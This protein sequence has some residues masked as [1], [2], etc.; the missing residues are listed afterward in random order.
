MVHQHARGSKTFYPLLLQD[1]EIFDVVSH[2]V[3]NLLYIDTIHAHMMNF[4]EKCAH[5][6]WSVHIGN[7]ISDGSRWFCILFCLDHHTHLILT[8]NNN[9]LNF[10]WCHLSKG[11]L[12]DLPHACNRLIRGKRKKKKIW[13]K[14]MLQLN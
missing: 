4:P 12:K 6:Y 10:K 2:D 1:F 11:K 14:E 7:S 8:R 13:V 5:E 3:D 9:V